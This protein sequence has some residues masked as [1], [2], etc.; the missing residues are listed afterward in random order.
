MPI[1]LPTQLHL[2]PDSHTHTRTH[3]VHS[4]IFFV[5]YFDYNYNLVCVLFPY[6]PYTR[7]PKYAYETLCVGRSSMSVCVCVCDVWRLLQR[8][9]CQNKKLKRFANSATGRRFR[10]CCG[11]VNRDFVGYSGER[12]RIEDFIELEKNFRAFKKL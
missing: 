1:H 4:P 5:C 8:E 11:L 3:G 10:L 6:S 9:E 12:K 7:V 2:G